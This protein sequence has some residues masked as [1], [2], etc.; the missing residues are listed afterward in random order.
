MDVDFVRGSDWRDVKPEWMAGG[1]G[2]DVQ[3]ERSTGDVKLIEC[4]TSGE[5]IR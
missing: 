4:G 1:T 5:L 3:A 2:V